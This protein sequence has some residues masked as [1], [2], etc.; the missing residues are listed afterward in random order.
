MII[1]C[2]SVN[3]K[4]KHYLL[5]F[6]INVILLNFLKEGLFLFHINL[7]MCYLVFCIEDS[8]DEALSINEMSRHGVFKNITRIDD[9]L[10]SVWKN[11]Q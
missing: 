1:V 9:K 5:L 11:T 2:Y 3:H 6:V 10:L 7:K 4:L 8:L